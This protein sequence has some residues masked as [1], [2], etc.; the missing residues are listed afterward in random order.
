VHKIVHRA[1]RCRAVN[2]LEYPGGQGLAGVAARDE[3]Y[4]FT[5]QRAR[6]IAIR[7]DLLLKRTSELARALARTSR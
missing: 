4:E 5:T 2:D 1:T 6:P 7:D 3:L